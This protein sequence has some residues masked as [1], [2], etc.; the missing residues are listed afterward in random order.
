MLIILKIKTDNHL[1]TF[2]LVWLIWLNPICR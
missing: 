1:E 2:Q